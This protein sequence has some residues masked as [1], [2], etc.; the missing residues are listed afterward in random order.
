MAVNSLF[1]TYSYE[2][3]QFWNVEDD[4]FQL[5]LNL[6]LIGALVNETVQKVTHTQRMKRI[7]IELHRMPIDISQMEKEGDGDGNGKTLGYYEKCFVRIMKIKRGNE[8]NADAKEEIKDEDEDE[9]ENV[10]DSFRSLTSHASLDDDSWDQSEMI[11]GASEDDIVHMT[12]ID[13]DDTSDEKEQGDE[14]WETEHK[15][16]LYNV[17]IFKVSK[18]KCKVTFTITGKVKE[19]V[20]LFSNENQVQAFSKM[21]ELQKSRMEERMK[22]NMEKAMEYSKQQLKLTEDFSAS[23]I[24]KFLIEIVGAVGCDLSNVHGSFVKVRFGEQL[25]HKTKILRDK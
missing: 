16:P 13:E 17:S 3:L 23:K 5:P 11:T 2:T 14:R 12:M 10:D 21:L 15:L 18:E 20:F 9:D 1:S 6:P 4:V 19:E 8:P 7:S 25:I 22:K 24:Q